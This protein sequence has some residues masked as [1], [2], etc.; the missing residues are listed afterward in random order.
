VK[1]DLKTPEILAAVELS[2][3]ETLYQGTSVME[4]D[5]KARCPVGDPPKHLRD[6]IRSEVNEEKKI[7]RVIVGSKR[8]KYSGAHAYMVEFGTAPHE[9]TVGKEKRTLAIPA[10]QVIL[11]RKV[12]HPGT[13]AQPFM[14]PAFDENAGKVSEFYRQ[15]WDRNVGRTVGR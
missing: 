10:R 11:G 15:H 2:M 6:A 14:R 7:G 5:A 4:A 1:L 13:S 3:V 9:I 8:G 12:Q